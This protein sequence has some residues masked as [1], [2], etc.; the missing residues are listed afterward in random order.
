MAGLLQEQMQAP[1]P[2]QPGQEP[3]Q[4]PPQGPAGPPQGPAGSPP[5]GQEAAPQGDGGEQQMYDAITEAMLGYL[6]DAG[7]E[8][9]ERKLANDPDPILS[10]ASAMAY[11]MVA[12]LGMLQDRGKTVPP[13]V[14]AQAGMELADNVGQIADA[15]GIVSI[16]DDLAVEM[17]YFIALDAMADEIPD[18]PPGTREQYKMIAQ[19][20]RDE[21]MAMMDPDDLPP[22]V[23]EAMEAEGGG[24]GGA[25]AGGPGAQPPPGQ[26]APQQPPVQQGGQPPMTEEDMP[27]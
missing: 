1:Q 2:A 13:H 27:L 18:N 3:T 21:R 16:E 14:M 7:M 12:A 22:E 17:A 9:V 19:T 25:P 20:L 5:P 4:Q 8:N 24:Q 11:I 10:M 15:M 6:Y 26:A 23:L